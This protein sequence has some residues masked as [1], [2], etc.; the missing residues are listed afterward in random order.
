M[1]SF[2]ALKETER[3]KGE[4]EDAKKQFDQIRSSLF[5]TNALIKINESETTR[6]QLQKAYQ[7][8]LAQ[9]TTPISA[10]HALAKNDEKSMVPR[11]TAKS[12]GNAKN[13]IRIKKRPSIG[14]SGSKAQISSQ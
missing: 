7:S 6:E 14:M 8:S 12:A 9:S 10:N 5:N 11:N 3:A 13:V 4:D 1:G 2:G